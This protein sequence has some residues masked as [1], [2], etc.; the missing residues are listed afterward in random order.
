MAWAFHSPP[1][2]A[3]FVSD[4]CQGQLD[5]HGPRSKQS[6]L[7]PSPP[8]ATHTDVHTPHVSS[9]S[10]PS[11]GSSSRRE[12]DSGLCLFPASKATGLGGTGVITCLHLPVSSPT[13]VRGAPPT[14]TCTPPSSCSCPGQHLTL[15]CPQ[16]C[17]C[18]RVLSGAPS[19][20]GSPPPPHGFSPRQRPGSLPTPLDGARFWGG[21]C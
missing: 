3:V 17:S 12:S 5:S 8:T 15:S 7:Q 1:L 16:V 14:A 2:I 10:E 13:E 20:G 4:S 11:T 21:G 6:C 19:S 18:S 9:C